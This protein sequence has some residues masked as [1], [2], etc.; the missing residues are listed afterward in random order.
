MSE[1]KRDQ[2]D[3]N[4]NEQIK[5][6]IKNL[7]IKTV[8]MGGYSKEDVHEC[9]EQLCAMY[10]NKIALLQQQLQLQQK[11]KSPANTIAVGNISASAS[12]HIKALEKENEA[13]RQQLSKDRDAKDMIAEVMMDARRNS[14]LIIKE[15]EE[16]ADAILESVD[17][18]TDRRILYRKKVL[19]SLEAENAKYVDYIDNLKDGISQIGENLEQLRDKMIDMNEEMLKP[20][21]AFRDIMEE[22]IADDEEPAVENVEPEEEQA[23]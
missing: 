15:A 21:P 23:E 19:G 11:T 18:E 3:Q 14:D 12:E 13:L 10:E 20:D 8:A 7:K 16:K 2:N 9:I 17:K 6:F 1:V 4:N 22:D 5:E